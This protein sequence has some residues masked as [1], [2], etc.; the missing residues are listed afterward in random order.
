MAP[1]RTTTVTSRP[2]SMSG[3]RSARP[4]VTT[5]PACSV[6]VAR[7]V[8]E[9]RWILPREAPL[10]ADARCGAPAPRPASFPQRPR[11]AAPRSRPVGAATTRRPHAELHGQRAGVNRVAGKGHLEC[12]IRRDVRGQGEPRDLDVR[13]RFLCARGHRG[14]DRLGGRGRVGGHG[15]GDAERAARVQ[16]HGGWPHS[17]HQR[18]RLTAVDIISSAAWMTFEESS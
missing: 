10:R 1:R 16:D 18:L 12:R 3:T 8:S 13:R 7:H 5:C 15:K 2:I 14:H 4:A 9:G 11:G 6:P 17:V